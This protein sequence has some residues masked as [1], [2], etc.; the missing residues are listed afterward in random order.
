MQPTMIV[1]AAGMGSRYGGLKQL[2]PVGPNGE[3][4][5]DYSVYDT[6]RAGFGKIVFIIRRDIEQPFRETIGS[7]YEKRL[8][9][10][11]AFQQLD[12]VPAGFVV[13]ANRQKPWGTGQAVLITEP[14]IREPFA[15]INADDFYGFESFQAL[16][17]HLSRANLDAT[18]YA[19]VG[20]TLRHTLSD[21]GSVSRGVCQ[22][23]ADGYLDRLRELTKI[24][25]FD[26]AARYTDDHG[27]TH[28][29]TGEEIV[30]MNMWGFTPAIY[31]QLRQAFSEFLQAQGQNEKA[32]FYI[33]SAVGQL[34]HQNQARVKVLPTDGAW[35]GITYREDKPAV[36]ASLRALIARGDYPERLWS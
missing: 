36:I 27:A 29:L 9:I 10:A 30:S 33:P 35:F 18:D 5:I 4:I 26:N 1:M 13:P 34:V 3:T 20:Y 6:I 11:Y 28:R 16:A 7:R 32:E 24:E 14:F 22:I 8:P 2:D 19:M 25:R 23:T 21:H 17:G 15:V 31:P 12:T